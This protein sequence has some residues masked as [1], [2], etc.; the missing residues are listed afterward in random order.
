MDHIIVPDCNG[1][2][3]NWN[4]THYTLL[5]VTT[6]ATAFTSLRA[7][8]RYLF[9]EDFTPIAPSTLLIYTKSGFNP[10]PPALNYTDPF[11][12]LNHNDFYYSALYLGPAAE[13]ARQWHA[14]NDLPPTERATYLQYTQ[15]LLT[16]PPTAFSRVR[17]ETQL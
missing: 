12:P 17:H 6:S 9:V 8:S 11:R 16:V 13:I 15:R 1:P 5:T 3:H 14:A 10:A 2:V 4:F 7:D